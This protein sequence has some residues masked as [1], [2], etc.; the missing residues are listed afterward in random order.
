MSRSVLDRAGKIYPTSPIYYQKY[1]LGTCARIASVL[2]LVVIM[3]TY[4]EK[5]N[6]FHWFRP[7]P[8]PWAADVVLLAAWGERDGETFGSVAR[9]ARKSPNKQSANRPKGADVSPV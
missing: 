9:R 2:A 8:C 5:A 6:I 3:G 1:H 7:H 4:H